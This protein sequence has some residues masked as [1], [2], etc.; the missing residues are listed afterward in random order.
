MC[1]AASVVTQSPPW[2]RRTRH[3]TAL[4]NL[5]TMCCCCP[6]NA[7]WKICA[8]PRNVWALQ[9][10]F[11][12]RQHLSLP[13]DIPACQ[14]SLLRL[15]TTRCSLPWQV[16]L[17]RPHNHARAKGQK[18]I[19][20]HSRLIIMI[21]APSTTAFKCSHR[22]MLAPSTHQR[23][24]GHRWA[25]NLLIIMISAPPFK[26]IQARPP[27]DACF[28]NTSEGQRSVKRNDSHVEGCRG[29]ASHERLEWDASPKEGGRG[30][31]VITQYLACSWTCGGPNEMHWNSKSN[32]TACSR[33]VCNVANN[34]FF[35]DCQSS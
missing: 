32:S 7:L 25:I 6:L 35:E 33:S 28:K 3:W 29:K 26:S 16:Y 5:K 18:G 4:L 9:V 20:E 11:P 31:L 23:A 19:G 15:W 2:R 21:T 13:S 12:A 24:R 14:W 30:Q 34:G 17:R 1:T 27:Q 8:L 10:K 22:G